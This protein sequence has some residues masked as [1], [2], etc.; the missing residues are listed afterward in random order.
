MYANHG[1]MAQG[2]ADPNQGQLFHIDTVPKV[3]SA[4]AAGVAP[5]LPMNAPGFLPGVTGKNRPTEIKNKVKALGILQQGRERVIGVASDT[6]VAD[7]MRERNIY[8]QASDAPADWYSHMRGD[9]MTQ[10]EAPRWIEGAA[11]RQGVSVNAMTRATAITSP[12]TRWTDG[13]A[14][15]T[16]DWSRPN[17]DAAEAVIGSVTKGDPSRS[18]E[19]IVG[20]ARSANSL[21]G[22]GALGS[23]AQKAAE[24]HMATG[25]STKDPLP[26]KQAGSLKVPNFEQSLHL[27]NPE[28]AVRR[29]AAG[30]YTVDRH[31]LTTAGLDDKTIKDANGLGYQAAAM[32]GQRAALKVGEL[33]PNFQARTWEVAR[34]E[35]SQANP[36]SMGENRLFVT[37][38]TGRMHPNPT[39]RPDRASDQRSSFAKKAG[40]DF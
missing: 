9:Q 25:G 32:T 34:S 38:R 31:D 14:M 28:Q 18:H 27:S 13:G 36:V 30:S 16:T 19:Q 2:A 26:I 12:Q 21:A 20:D 7:T 22:R 4:A 3:D 1:L 11:G 8:H 24:V 40:L 39:A 15:G 6:P 33:P 29:Q 23:M 5:A 37:D 35:S 17:L 10:G